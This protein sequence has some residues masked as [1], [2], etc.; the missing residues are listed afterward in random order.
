MK[1]NING[2]SAVKDTKRLRKLLPN[3]EILY[4]ILIYCKR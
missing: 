3:L 4:F 1:H 2:T